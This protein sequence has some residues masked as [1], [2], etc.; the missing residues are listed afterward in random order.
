MGEK[1]H[2]Q[3]YSIEPE[4]VIVDLARLYQTTRETAEQYHTHFKK[5]R[6]RI[7]YVKP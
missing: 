4:V 3:F 1:F 7:T 2:A 6:T 5:A